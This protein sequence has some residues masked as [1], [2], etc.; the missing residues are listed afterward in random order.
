MIFAPVLTSNAS[1]LSGGGGKSGAA[2]ISFGKS[3]DSITIDPIASTPGIIDVDGTAVEISSQQ[4][5]ARTATRLEGGT[6]PV[7][8]NAYIYAS[9]NGTFAHSSVAPEN[10]YHPNFDGQRAVAGWRH[11]NGSIAGLSAIC[12]LI[13]VNTGFVDRFS[14]LDLTAQQDHLVLSFSALAMTPETELLIFWSLI[15]KHTGAGQ[16]YIFA[17][18][19]DHPSGNIALGNS[20]F[21]YAEDVPHSVCGSA[22]IMAGNSFKHTALRLYINK[23]SASGTLKVLEHS[24]LSYIRM[25]G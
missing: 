15:F 21:S 23:P 3:G 13:G 8:S 19:L 9:K 24:Y 7:N 25:P 17:G 11:S 5:L 2:Q 12:P 18:R 16:N 1:S 20:E 14:N 6:V 10:G 22:K 4:L